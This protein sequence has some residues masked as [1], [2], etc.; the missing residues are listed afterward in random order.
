M[1][2]GFKKKFIKVNK[3]KIFCRI[4]GN[5]PPLL[6]LHGYPQ[7]H[8]MWNKTAPELSKNFTL[9]VADL[10][11]Y[12]NRIELFSYYPIFPPQ[13]LNWDAKSFIFI[14]FIML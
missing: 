12:G 8:V 10:R 13:H 3:G 2:E 14:F 5:G 4:K 7:T 6:L 1:F 9:V 11:G